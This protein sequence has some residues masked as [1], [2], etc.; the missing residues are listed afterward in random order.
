MQ[1][2]AEPDPLKRPNSFQLLGRWLGAAAGVRGGANRRNERFSEGST[3]AILGAI[4][5]F[6]SFLALGMWAFVAA[7]QRAVA[8]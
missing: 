1:K 6:A 8:G 5:I 2:Q 4:L 3:L 7:V